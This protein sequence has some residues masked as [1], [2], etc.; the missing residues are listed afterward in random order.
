[1]VF[2]CPCS[3]RR[4]PLRA[5]NLFVLV[6]VGPPEAHTAGPFYLAHSHGEGLEIGAGQPATLAIAASRA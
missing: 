6:L 3:K 2:F 4:V 1:V 5:F